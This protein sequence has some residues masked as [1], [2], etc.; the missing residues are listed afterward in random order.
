MSV[1]YP[2]THAQQLLLGDYPLIFS[3]CGLIDICPVVFATVFHSIA[4]VLSTYANDW[5]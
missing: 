1:E 3:E 2:S 5:A 4:V